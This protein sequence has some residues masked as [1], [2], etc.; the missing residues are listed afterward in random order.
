MFFKFLK[1]LYNLLKNILLDVKYTLQNDQFNKDI[2][3]DMEVKL[4]D[5]KRKRK[6]ICLRIR[7]IFRTKKTKFYF[8]NLLK[9]FLYVLYRIVEIFVT[10]I[11][12]MLFCNILKLLFLIYLHSYVVTFINYIHTLFNI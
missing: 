11:V 7:V 3:E 6:N 5:L 2:S 1:L 8:K 4:F 10:G 12:F 9:R